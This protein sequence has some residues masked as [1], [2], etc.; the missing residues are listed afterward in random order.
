MLRFVVRHGLVRLIGRRAVPAL[1][2]WDVA[3]LANKA[4]QIPVVDRGLRRGASAARH[5]AGAV[6]TSP[7]WPT[8][9]GRPGRP[10]PEPPPRDPEPDA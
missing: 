5:G 2:A 3:V 10:P 6:V 9:P 7:R 4:R 8:R 1:I